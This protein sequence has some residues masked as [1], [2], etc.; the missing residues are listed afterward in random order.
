MRKNKSSNRSI[1]KWWDKNSTSILAGSGIGM[2]IGAV[3]STIPATI[4]A[5]N[6]CDVIKKDIEEHNNIKV[7]K[8]RPQEIIK[9][10]WKY[11]ILPL[12]LT[13]GGTVC[14]LGSVKTSSKQKARLLTMATSAQASLRE[15]KEVT[16]QVV[17]KEKAAEIKEKVKEQNE[18]KIKETVLTDPN[19]ITEMWLLDYHGR[20]FKGNPNDI[21]RDINKFNLD[22]L[23]RGDYN[24]NINDLYYAID[25]PP[26]ANGDYEIWDFSRDKLPD[27]RWIPTNFKNRAAL[28][29]DFYNPPRYD[30]SCL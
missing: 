25:R 5:K 12:G 17:G 16:E 19:D 10:C 30:N 18:Q 6:K 23:Q 1:A 9:N 2:F 24:A 21:D 20:P 13:I 29:L 7:E 28:K 27:S 22:C 15:Y 11:Y 3:G 4:K 14:V 26:V 8:L